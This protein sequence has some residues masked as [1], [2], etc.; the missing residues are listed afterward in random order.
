MEGMASKKLWTSEPFDSVY[1]VDALD[2]LRDFHSKNPD[3]PRDS[4]LIDFEY[5]FSFSSFSFSR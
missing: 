5:V 2:E 4:Y 1:S 3:M